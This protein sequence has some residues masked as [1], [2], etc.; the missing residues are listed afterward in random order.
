MR[1]LTLVE[2]KTMSVQ[3]RGMD[4]RDYENTVLS[5][6]LDPTQAVRFWNIMDRAKERNP[7]VSRSDVIRELFG[8]APLIALTEE[9]VRSF[10]SVPEG[11]ELVYADD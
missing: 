7:Y 1:Q 8:L 2:D 9:D 11:E 3:T 4:K 6:R 5:L 10:R